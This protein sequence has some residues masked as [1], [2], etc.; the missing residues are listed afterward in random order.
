M[1]QA[2]IGYVEIGFM[3]SALESGRETHA[4]DRVVAF[5][6]HLLRSESNPNNLD[7]RMIISSGHCFD[8]HGTSRL[9]GIKPSGFS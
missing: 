8:Q 7:D 6:P 1:R 3:K 4:E 5:G 2:G 9:A